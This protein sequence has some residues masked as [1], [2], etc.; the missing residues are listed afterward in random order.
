MEFIKKYI[1]SVLALLILLVLM[2]PVMSFADD[3]KP[4][5]GK[6]CNPI[7]QDTITEFLEVLVT[8][9]VRIGLPVI[10]LAIIYSGF[11][12]V[13]ARGNPEELTKAKDALLYTM[14]GAG[15][16]LGAWAL[17]TLIEQTVTALK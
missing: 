13:K 5:G 12:F 14:I 1:P 11:L 15:V 3:C 16:L 4:D 10:V 7:E 2:L 17:A 8:G 9:V 6:I